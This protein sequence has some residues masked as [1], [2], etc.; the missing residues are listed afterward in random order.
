MVKVIIDNRE[1]H[2]NII[3][4]LIEKGI[5]VEIKNLEVG[6]FIASDRVV[7]ERKTV[8]DFL[9]SII[10]KRIFEQ[11]SKMNKTYEKPIIIIEGEEDIYSERNIHPNALRGVIISLAVD[12]KIPIIFSQSE[13]ETALFIQKLAEREQI[14]QKRIPSIRNEKKPLQDKYIQEYIVS[15][16]PGVGRTT[17]IKMLEHFKNLQNIFNAKQEDLKNVERIGEEKSKRIRE[18]IEREYEP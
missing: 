11:A 17:A 15:S 10:D 2:S 13:E 16:L 12:F 18:I 7:I 4:L 14:E 5:E 1:L 9:Q 8:K 3:N 6:D